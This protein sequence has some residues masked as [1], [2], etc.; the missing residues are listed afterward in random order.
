MRNVLPFP[1]R[2]PPFLEIKAE[3]CEGY[4]YAIR[5]RDERYR[6]LLIWRGKS[7][8]A[9]TLRAAEYAPAFQL[10]V[11]DLSAPGARR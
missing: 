4:A 1:P 9:A 8:K 2:R 11:V 6:A 10:P 3:V 5:F 7:R